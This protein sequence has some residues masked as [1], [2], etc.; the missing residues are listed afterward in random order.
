MAKR[1]FNITGPCVPALHYMVDTT[2]KIEK[3]IRDY[4]DN[5]YYF[6]INRARQYGKT[7]TLY[8]LENDLRKNYITINISFEGIGSTAF[9][10]ERHFVQ[11]FIRLC[12][13]S[14]SET[15]EASEIL[16]QWKR[17][18]KISD[19]SELNTS[20]TEFVRAVNKKT[21]LMIDEV[22]K[23]SNQQLFLDFLGMLRDKF[24]KRSTRNVPTFHS[25]ILVSVHDIKNLKL[26]LRPDEKSMLNS[27]WNIATAFEIDMSF[28]ASEIQTMLLEYEADYQ[29]GMDVSSVASR[30][31]Y[32][33]SGYPF[34]VSALCKVIYDCKL[35]WTIAGVDEAKK[36][37]S[38]T[39]NTLFDDVIKNI[40]N[41]RSFDHLLRRI[42]YTGEQV[43]YQF[44]NPDI[45]LGSMYGILTEQDHKVAV[46]NLIFKSV[47]TDYYISVDPNREKI[48]VFEENRYHFIKNDSLDMPL[49][50][51]RFAEFMKQEY[52][53]QDS[54]FIER[55]GR[56]LF[57]G[58]LKPII[59]GT[60]HYDIESEIRGDRRM[61]LVVHYGVYSYIIEL[62]IWH[63][64]RAAQRALEQLKGYLSIKQ[65]KTGY[66]L[67]FCDN[68]KAPRASQVH[69]LDGYMIYETVVAYRD[70]E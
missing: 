17:L 70:K 44:N 27:P 52:R 64:N 23:S 6:T 39:R 16:Q 46:S 48:A 50:M 24:I 30:I 55:E 9:L 54:S 66:L 3:I 63:G 4:I 21:I 43:P 12:Y 31:F 15:G 42:L 25:V 53:D 28:S 37:I 11:T 58:F 34:L 7:T 8:L 18:E 69:E 19:F 57:L 14:M 29:T 26:R 47:I 10:D 41:H 65:E 33:T 2:A 56:L 60:G 1:T 45:E 36:Q 49:I 68:K 67:S 62:K 13:Q 32:Y 22:D 35:P 51:E 61:D 20:V 40:S 5:G 38:K 59:N